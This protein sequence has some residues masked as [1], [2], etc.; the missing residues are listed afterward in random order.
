MLF[1]HI[2]R[3][4]IWTNKDEMVCFAPKTLYNLLILNVASSS[5]IVLMPLVLIDYQFIC[6]NPNLLKLKLKLGLPEEEKQDIK[7]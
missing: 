2:N 7:R 6:F 5:N 1:G 4:Y 3:W